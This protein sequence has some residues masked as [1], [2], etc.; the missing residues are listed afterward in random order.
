M[1]IVHTLVRAPP[2][3]RERGAA[4][5]GGPRYDREGREDLEAGGRGKCADAR[6]EPRLRLEERTSAAVLAGSPFG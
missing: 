6:L 1:A 5:A 4:R 2:E 3:G